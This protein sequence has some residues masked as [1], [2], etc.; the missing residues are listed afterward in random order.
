V[1]AIWGHRGASLARPENT[2][3]AFIEAA[4]QG[5]EGVELDVRRA[6]DGALV[7]HHDETL[8]D[9]RAIVGL[10]AGDLPADVCLLDAA[11]DACGGMVVNIEIKNVEV[12]GD[13]D[14]DEYLAGAVTALLAQRNGA[15]EVIVSSFSLAT[16]DRVGALAPGVARGYLA[17]P[18][19]NQTEA[20]ARAIDHGHQAFHPHHL[21]VNAEIVTAAHAAGLAVNVWTVDEP[22]RIRW[23]ADLGIDSIITNAPDIARAAL[24]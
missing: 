16:I 23:L 8:P 18:R 5:A 21:V 9:G 20:L 11:L 22:E 6:A 19:W 15:D 14:P 4:A 13:Y 7:V 12:D 24:A 3:A 1:P 17:S 10:T 2:L